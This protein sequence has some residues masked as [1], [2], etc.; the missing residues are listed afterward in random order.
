MA[1]NSDGLAAET[2]KN[3]SSKNLL[4]EQLGFVPEDLEI[5]GLSA[6]RNDLRLS[7]AV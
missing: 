4:N 7:V 6:C 3:L 5:V 1:T 2:W